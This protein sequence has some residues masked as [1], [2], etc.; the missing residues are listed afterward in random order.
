MCHN[1]SRSPHAR[2]R[3]VIICTIAW[4]LLKL[5]SGNVHYYGQFTMEKN[6]YALKLKLYFLCHVLAESFHLKYKDIVSILGTKYRRMAWSCG[7]VRL[8]CVFTS[9]ALF[10]PGFNNCLRKRLFPS[11]PAPHALFHYCGEGWCL[12]QAAALWPC[13]PHST[14]VV[15]VGPTDP[16]SAQPHRTPLAQPHRPLRKDSPCSQPHRLPCAQPH[17][18]L[19]TGPLSAAP[20]A[21]A[22]RHAHGAQFE[23]CFCFW[24]HLKGIPGSRWE[25]KGQAGSRCGQGCS[26]M[27][28]PAFVFKWC[29]AMRC[30]AVSQAGIGA[31]ALGSWRTSR[32][33]SGLICAKAAVWENRI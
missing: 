13:R 12:T 1:P 3:F 30:E 8:A 31:T 16:K 21:C 17:R 9:A 24:D 20:Q 15:G 19:S 10:H 18:P 7:S 26:P 4:G 2:L 28:V 22:H 5:V 14:R 6:R 27:A 33:L 25:G 29:L 32:I 23:E 11:C